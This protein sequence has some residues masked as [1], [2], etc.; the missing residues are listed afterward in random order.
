[1]VPFS[2]LSALGRLFQRHPLP[3]DEELIAYAAE[4]VPA[5]ERAERLYQEWFEQAALFA[6]HERLANAAAIHRWEAA[7][8]ARALGQIAPPRALGRSHAD[9]VTALHAASRAAQLLSNGTRF[10]NGHAVC[11][12]QT[13]LEASR[14]RRLAAATAIWRILRPRLERNEELSAKGQEIGVGT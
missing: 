4:M 6:D 13:L 11:D 3:S 7:T 14:N 5:L 1:M 2:A 12:G 10:H 8:L 9:L